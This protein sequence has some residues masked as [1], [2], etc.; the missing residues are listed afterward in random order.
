MRLTTI[1]IL[2]FLFSQSSYSQ[3]IVYDFS[4]METDDASKAINS[5][6]EL[7]LSLLKTFGSS[8][9]LSE[10]IQLGEKLLKEIKLKNKL[11]ESGS[12]YHQV[13][14]ILIKL[15]NNIINPR[16]FNYS[17][18]V[19][20]SEDLNG[21]T[22]GGKI[23][24][25]TKMVQ[26]CTNES[27]IAAVLSHEIAHNELSHIA[28]NISREKTASIF[29]EIGDFTAFFGSLL[30]TPFNQRNEVHSDLVGIDIM[31][32]SGYDICAVSALWERMEA[33]ETKGDI[34]DKISSTHP[35][36]TTR[37]SCSINHISNNYSKICY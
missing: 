28:D 24:I 8:V 7:E 36:S 12:V 27:E 2:F 10:E 37:R 15:Q 3:K 13:K 34:I 21:F 1:L 23:F 26:F 11:I 19:I 32:K 17:I 4:C 31:Y 6:A 22:C 9:S 29:G 30:T 33:N 20:D 25:T 14:Q 35:N 5:A 18:Y 16:G